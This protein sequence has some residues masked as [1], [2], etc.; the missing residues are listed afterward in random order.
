MCS[1]I[2]KIW[3]DIQVVARGENARVPG[4]QPRAPLSSRPSAKVASPGAPRAGD[5]VIGL[6]HPYLPQHL[7]QS[8][9]KVG[10]FFVRKAP[11]LTSSEYPLIK[12]ESQFTNLGSHAKAWAS[13]YTVV[14]I[15]L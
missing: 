6:L 12:L 10:A 13:N 4:R 14:I 2:Q 8:H 5:P 9:L 11:M 1:D 7:V 15:I 3:L